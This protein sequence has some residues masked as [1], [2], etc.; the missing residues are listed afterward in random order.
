MSAPIPMRLTCP[1]CGQLHVDTGEFATRSHHTHACQN[2]GHVWRPAVVA[3]V[4]VRFLPGFKDRASCAL[5]PQLSPGP[6]PVSAAAGQPEATPTNA[7]EASRLEAPSAGLGEDSWDGSHPPPALAEG[8][9]PECCDAAKAL[10]SLR[11]A[12]DSEIGWHGDGELDDSGD[13]LIRLREAGKQ[14]RALKRTKNAVERAHANIQADRDR[15]DTLVLAAREVLRFADDSSLSDRASAEPL[16]T[17][18]EKL[19][20]ALVEYDDYMPF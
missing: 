16:A 1:D 19:G 6:V 14:L 10:E 9:A 7:S 11:D 5:E 2:C 3:T 18:I 4:G 20:K 8:G 15:A 12:I 17:A 13:Y